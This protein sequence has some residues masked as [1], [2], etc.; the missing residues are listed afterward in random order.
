MRV[1]INWRL[2]LWNSLRNICELGTEIFV[3]LGLSR[4]IEPCFVRVQ[5]KKGINGLQV[6]M[7]A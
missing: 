2:L 6:L 3:T 7:S 5:Q 4:G 1:H